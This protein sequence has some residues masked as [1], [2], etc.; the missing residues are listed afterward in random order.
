M[1]K[2]TVGTYK[3]YG[4]FTSA[5]IYGAGHMVPSDQPDVA[6]EML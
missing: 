3:K 2:N 5:T 4:S 6:Y 1:N